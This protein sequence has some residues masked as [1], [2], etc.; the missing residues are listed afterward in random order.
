MPA[1]VVIADALAF[2]QERRANLAQ[3]TAVF[4]ARAQ[5]RYAAEPA[6]YDANGRA[7][8][9]TSRQTGATP[10]G[11][12]PTPP[13]PGPRDKDQGHV[14]APE[15][16]LM[17]NSPTDG[18]DQHDQ[19]QAAVAQASGVMV[20]S[21]LSHPPHAPAEAL[22]PVDASPLA[23]GTPQAGALD[24]GSCRATT[25]AAM[26]ARDRAPSLAT[27]RIP[28]HPRWPSSGAPPPA[29]PPAPASPKLQRAHT[30]PSEMGGAISRWRNG[31]VEP[32]LGLIHDL[33]GVRQGALRGVRAA[34][35][36]WW[37]GCLAFNWTRLQTL[38]LDQGASCWRL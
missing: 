35:G 2:G 9:A 18:F 37:L 17:D 16:R 22:P 38:T 5:E 33:V 27:G 32:V 30:R 28:H 31:T 6:A 23:W 36:A 25:I 24:P 14:T 26:D 34:A 19:A 12:P 10:R 11:R 29:P 20:A 7:R 21:P 4:A 15:S 13:T 3:A 1:G 8:D